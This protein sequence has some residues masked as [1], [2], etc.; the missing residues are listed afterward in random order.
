[1]KTKYVHVVGIRCKPRLEEKWNKWYDE[2]H[3]P[4]LPTMNGLIGVTRYKISP[5]APSGAPMTTTASS[6]AEE[7]SKY[8]AIF[9]FDTDEDITGFESSLN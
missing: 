2:I 8:L 4:M 9:E 7:Y 5:I 6:K 3:I 1:M